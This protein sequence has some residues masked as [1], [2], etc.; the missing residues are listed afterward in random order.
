VGEAVS[1][2]NRR[3]ME[4]MDFICLISVFVLCFAFKAICSIHV[5]GFVITSIDEHACRV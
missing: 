2:L 3:R 5:F 4:G 1:A